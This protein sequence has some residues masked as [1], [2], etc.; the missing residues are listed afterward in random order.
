MARTG[1]VYAGLLHEL[2][3]DRHGGRSLSGELWPEPRAADRAQGEVR[4]D[5]PLPPERERASKGLSPQSGQSRPASSQRA[6]VAAVASIFAR[7]S[8]TADSSGVPC[9]SA[10]ARS[11]CRRDSSRQP[12]SSRSSDKLF[13]GAG[14]SGA[15]MIARTQASG[16]P[17]RSAA[18]YGA[19]EG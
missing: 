14:S 12:A 2:H 7:L 17:A 8:A 5:E 10:A 6:T 15:S 4:P 13:R 9:A 18:A 3:A 16:A 11:T 1:A 19:L